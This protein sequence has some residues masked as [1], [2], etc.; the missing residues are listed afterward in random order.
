MN[1]ERSW[2]KSRYSNSESACVELSVTTADTAV[3]DTK[4]RDGGS[5]QLNNRAFTAFTAFTAA[6]AGRGDSAGSQ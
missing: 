3:R 2:H 1:T 4:D 5:L 6:T